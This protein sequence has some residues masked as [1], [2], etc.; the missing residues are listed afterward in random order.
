MHADRVVLYD[1]SKA[2]QVASYGG[3]SRIASQPVLRVGHNYSLVCEFNGHK[4]TQ[5]GTNFFRT[6]ILREQITISFKINRL[7][8]RGGT[9]PI[10]ANIDRVLTGLN[11]DISVDDPKSYAS[12]VTVE[13]QEDRTRRIS[14]S[15]ASN[16]INGSIEWKSPKA[17]PILHIDGNYQS[18]PVL[19]H[20]HGLKVGYLFQFRDFKNERRSFVYVGEKHEIVLNPRELCLATCALMVL[21][22][23][24]VATSVDDICVAAAKRVLNGEVPEGWKLDSAIKGEGFSE[25]RLQT[26]EA[27]K[28]KSDSDSWTY[29]HNIDSL[30]AAVMDDLISKSFPLQPRFS[31]IEYGTATTKESELRFYLGQGFPIIL[32]TDHEGWNHAIVCCGA[33]ADQNGKLLNIYIND[34]WNWSF[35]RL[36]VVGKG[37]YKEWIV[38]GMHLRI[39]EITSGKLLNRD[40][41]APYLENDT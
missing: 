19:V 40:G 31:K 35:D 7:P 30:I 9:L 1:I 27:G 12:P 5:P 2:K 34:P 21:R 4:V 25:V 37:N 14:Q 15:L 16:I 17:R 24:G 8:A 41:G 6:R 38:V 20:T 28:D 10:K 33:V 36:E 26:A 23:Y 32:T 3:V 29:P 13:V 11:K 18:Q 22:Y 39:A